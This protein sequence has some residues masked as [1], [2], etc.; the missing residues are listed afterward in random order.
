[1]NALKLFLRRQNMRPHYCINLYCDN[2]V[3]WPVATIVNT[4]I[5]VGRF[6]G[7]APFKSSYIKPHRATST[8]P[9]LSSHLQNKEHHKFRNKFT[10]HKQKE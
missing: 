6:D 7:D 9:F 1:M 2:I 4:I 8:S 5:Y 3:L 10:I